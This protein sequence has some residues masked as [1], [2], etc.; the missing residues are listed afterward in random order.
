[1]QPSS[2]TLKVKDEKVCFFY[3]QKSDIANTTE[4][5][6]VDYI[7]QFSIKNKKEAMNVTCMFLVCQFD[8]KICILLIIK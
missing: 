5:I 7:A 3:H 4:Q 2:D 8:K 6:T 1:M